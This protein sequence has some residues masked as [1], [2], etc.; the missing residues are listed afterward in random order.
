[1]FRNYFDVQLIL[2]K[3]WKIYLKI[4]DFSKYENPQKFW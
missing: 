1:M 4:P 3:L 2:L